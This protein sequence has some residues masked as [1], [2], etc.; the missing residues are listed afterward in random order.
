MFEPK[1]YV[2]IAC[3]SDTDVESWYHTLC[4]HAVSA[5]HSNIVVSTK[6]QVLWRIKEK[7]TTP[8]HEYFVAEVLHDDG[9]TRYLR[10]ERFSED[11]VPATDSKRFAVQASPL[12]ESLKTR[13]ADDRVF[14]YHLA[15]QFNVNHVPEV[16]LCG[17]CNPRAVDGE[18]EDEEGSGG[19]EGEDLLGDDE[20]EDEDEDEDQ[21]EGETS[22]PWAEKGEC[23]CECERIGM[24][25]YEV[26]VKDTLAVVVITLVSPLGTNVGVEQPKTHDRPALSFHRALGHSSHI[27][28]GP[29]GRSRWVL[30]GRNSWRRTAAL[31]NNSRM[32]SS[33]LESHGSHARA[34]DAAHHHLQRTNFYST[35]NAENPSL[36]ERNAGISLGIFALRDA[37]RSCWGGSGVMV[38]RVVIVGGAQEMLKM[39][40]AEYLHG[41]GDDHG[42]DPLRD[43]DRDQGQDQ[44]SDKKRVIVLVTTDGK[45]E[46]DVNDVG[47]LDENALPPKM[48][49]KWT[50]RTVKELDVGG[51]S[52]GAPADSGEDEG[53]VGGDSYVGVEMDDEVDETTCEGKTGI[54]FALG[55]DVRVNGDETVTILSTPTSISS[56]LRNVP[57]LPSSAAGTWREPSFSEVPVPDIPVCGESSTTLI[58]ILPSRE[59]SPLVPSPPPPVQAPPRLSLSD[60]KIRRERERK[61]KERERSDKEKDDGA[62]SGANVAVDGV[63]MMETAVTL[64]RPMSTRRSWTSTWI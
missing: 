38:M 22:W 31:G 49:K 12:G 24:E 64:C 20:D 52:P 5:E 27:K 17:R 8:E 10:I 54:R 46:A 25:T 34:S 63:K 26:K 42:L 58:P 55:V 43:I 29:F 11:Y 44:D 39:C 61:E 57:L 9:K 41:D 47:G 37:R 36:A 13:A 40:M 15:S 2:A 28:T 30:G 32:I 19:Q 6:A 60:W 23:E 3:P 33:R 51:G 14:T 1:S 18:E 48:R 53:G 21:D 16:Y 50:G 59:P 62:G 7:N 56:T 35:P 4:A 45:C